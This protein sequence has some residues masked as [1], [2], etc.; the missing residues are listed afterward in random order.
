MK[1]GVIV[2]ILLGVIVF[3]SFS[4]VSANM[5]TDFFNKIFGNDADLSPSDGTNPNNNIVCIEIYDP[6]CGTNNITYSNSCYANKYGISIQCEQACPCSIPD[7]TPI[8]CSDGTLDGRCSITKPKFCDE[9]RLIDKCSL[10]GCPSD[11]SVGSVDSYLCQ[12]DGSCKIKEPGPPPPEEAYFRFKL[13]GHEDTFIFKLNN[14]TKIQ[15][16]RDILNGI[17]TENIRVA[18]YINQEPVEYNPPWSYYLAPNSVYFFQQAIELCDAEIGYLEETLEEYCRQYPQGKCQWCPWGSVLIE[19][20]DI[21]KKC[22]D[23]T[24]YG[25]CSFDKPKFCEKQTLTLKDNCNLCGCPQ[26]GNEYICQ[27]DG[28][29]KLKIPTPINEYNESFEKDMGGWLLDHHLHCEQDS[30]PCSSLIWNISR[31]TNKSFEGDYS[32]KYYMDGTHDDGVIWVE[33]DF[34]LKPDTNYDL[35]ITFNLWSDVEK[36]IGRWTIVSYFGN[37]NPEIEEDFSS[38]GWTLEKAGWKEYSYKK[39]VRSDDAG[40]IW[41]AFGVSAVFETWRTHYLDYVTISINESKDS[42]GGLISTQDQATEKAVTKN[43]I[44]IIN[45][46]ETKEQDGKNIYIIDGSRKKRIL[47]LIPVNLNIKTQI[48]AETGEIISTKK[49]WWSFL[50]W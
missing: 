23:G 47:F 4:L 6:I 9:G 19:E 46:V 50:A 26:D 22:S 21:D 43:K 16:A 29:C 13:T 36:E 45:S 18:G 15:K 42:S 32:L 34:D 24:V 41:A 10:C 2:F 35:N 3:V 7:P 20:V 39:N 14:S 40:K 44:Q 17:E 12:E 27:S 37:V 1:K 38:V 25:S 28:S 5:F 49:S 48:D 31:S 11:P 30:P 8:K 33:K